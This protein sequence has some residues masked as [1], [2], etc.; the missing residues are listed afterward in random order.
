MIELTISAIVAALASGVIVGIFLGALGG[1]G[2]VL[3]A[4]LLI[5]FVGIS[6]PH[7]AIGTSAAAVAAIALFSLIGHWRGGRVKWP[8]AVVF[9]SSGLIGSLIGSTIAKS[10]SGDI[11]LFGFAIAMAA[12]GA[13]MLRPSNSAGDPGIRI[14]LKIMARIAPIGLAAGGAAGF[15]GIGGGF[16]IVPGLM[17]A[18]GMT[19]A[20]ATA[21]SLV[22]VTI[23][24]AATSANYALGGFVDI[25][26]ALLLLLG[27]AA[28]GLA[29]IRFAKA[30]E[31]R[32]RLARSIFAALIIFV[33]AFVGW[34]AG[35]SVFESGA[36]NG[37]SDH[38]P[39]QSQNTD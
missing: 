14:T 34:D 2:S 19:M 35:S 21:S 7:V 9:A 12:I 6:S 33:A 31:T 27:G 4:P 26:L 1:G 10:I 11:L 32:I 3:A 37:I 29:G 25:R 20:N 5:Y 15:F 18:T 30:L 13:S 39:S 36:E 28:G 8:C 16:L 24:G 23:F 17:L 22:S 38:A